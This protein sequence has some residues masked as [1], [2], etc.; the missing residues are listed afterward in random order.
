MLILI[1]DHTHTQSIV[2]EFN[3]P[4][5]EELVCF[6]FYLWLSDPKC[7]KLRHPY[8]YVSHILIPDS[9]VEQWQLLSVLGNNCLLQPTI[10]RKIFTV[11]KF[12]LYS[13]LESYCENIIHKITIATLWACKH[14]GHIQMISI[15]ENFICEL[16]HYYIVM[17]HLQNLQVHQYL[18]FSTT[19]ISCPAVPYI[20]CMLWLLNRILDVF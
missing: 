6:P 16:L 20:R 17:V 7:F 1:N 14:T 15:H 8:L 12:S 9:D 2:G 19:K 4:D 10:G 11:V 3:N 18:I 13:Q 5:Q